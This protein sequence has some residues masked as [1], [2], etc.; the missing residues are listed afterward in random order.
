ME[1]ASDEDEAPPGNT[2]KRKGKVGESS[3]K[4]VKDGDGNP[5]RE[6]SEPNLSIT[7]GSRNNSAVDKSY[8]GYKSGNESAS[9]SSINIPMI[10]WYPSTH[11]GPYNVLVKSAVKL[12]NSRKNI[13]MYLHE[14]LRKNK[15]TAN[16]II[17]EVGFNLFRLTFSTA[18]EANKFSLIKELKKID[19]E[20][21]IPDRFIQRYCIIKNVPLSFTENEIRDEIED[22]NALDV[23]SVYR[24]RR[25][26]NETETQSSGTVKIGFGSLVLPK[27]IKMFNSIV[28]VELYVPPLRQCKN[29][30]RLG[31]IAIRC[32]S[33]KRCL[34]CG[35]PI[36]CPENCEE[37]KCE[38]CLS[39]TRC[40][41]ECKDK[42]C[43]ICNSNEHSS[44]DSNKCPSWKKE[45]DIREIMALSN[46]SRKEVI[47]KYALNR[48]YYELLSDEEF[49][50]NF[51]PLPNKADI[52]T[53][54]SEEEINRRVTKIKYSK[55]AAA[56]PKPNFSQL[57]PITIIP[58]APS[59][60]RSNY[61]KVNEIEKTIQSLLSQFSSLLS[62]VNIN[63]GHNILENF[64]STVS[65]IKFHSTSTTASN[66]QQQTT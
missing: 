8:L 37:Q 17:K 23:I 36:P 26:V 14:K 60:S 45:K 15:I 49:S 59:Y 24:F 22:N 65:N 12:S 41:P 13:E 38:K 5:I 10:N 53:R 16:A 33:K 21:F 35:K 52:T 46:L 57:Q 29:C 42:K 66:A 47:Q 55:I 18:D 28:T 11:V 64:K 51:P 62:Q 48:N 4:V 56:R 1:M 39:T 31:H 27:T 19:L 61:L 7:S 44:S 58:S 34:E 63:D 32:K 30:G 2:A 25:R 43:I 3:S 50:T 9:G 6:G 40:D 20:A 54:D